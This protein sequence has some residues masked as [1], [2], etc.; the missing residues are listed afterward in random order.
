MEFNF[1]R[2]EFFKN[3]V[4]FKNRVIAHDILTQGAALSLYT[5]FALPPMVILL[6]KF[7]STLRLSL[8]QPMIEEV[9]ELM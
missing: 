5:I 7:L 6:L 8:Q 3:S 2:S 4:K 1:L 9:H